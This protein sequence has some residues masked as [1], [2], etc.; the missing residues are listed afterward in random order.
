M[1]GDFIVER[2]S[3]T[4]TT[5]PYSLSLGVPS[6]STYQRWSGG[7]FA[8]GDVVFY[9]ARTQPNSPGG[10]KYEEGWGVLAT[11]TAWTIT[12]NVLKS[13]NSNSAVDWQLQDLYVVYSAPV[14]VALGKLLV[15]NIAT[16]R[17]SWAQAGFEW[18]DKSAG[19]ASRW[20]RKVY[21][22]TSDVETGRYHAV[23]GVYTAAMSMDIVDNGAANLTISDMHRDKFIDFNVTAAGRTCTLGTVS[24]YAK[25]FA[26]GV[27]GYGATGNNVALTPDG[28]E[29]INEGAAGAALNIAGGAPK[30]VRADHVRGAWLVYG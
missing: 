26:F 1:L 12:R 13:S 24:S 18:F 6:N 2:C 7:D 20:L 27:Y 28:A 22:G 10:M 30:I 11:G 21:N 8:S 4:G 15:G 14:G 19:L 9:V 25:G 3:T 5:S 29:K 23:N 17:P 16:T